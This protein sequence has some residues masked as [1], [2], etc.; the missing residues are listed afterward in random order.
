MEYRLLSFIEEQVE[1]AHVG[2]EAV[3]LLIYP[4]IPLGSELCV[5]E[6]LLR[7]NGITEIHEFIAFPISAIELA[8]PSAAERCFFTLLRE[9]LIRH[10]YVR[11]DV[12]KLYHL[13]HDLHVEVEEE[14]VLLLIERADVVLVILEEGALAVCRE[15]RIPMHVAP[16][17]MIRDTDILHRHRRI[18]IR[19]DGESQRTIGG[20]YDHAIAISL[21]DETLMALYQALIVAMEFLIPLHRTEIGGRK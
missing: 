17:G 14:L 20:G 7:A 19:R 13:L 4:V 12:E 3:L 8:F 11:S 15:E 2:Q 6:R 1:D 10:L 18:V 9:V 16:I 5:W 21:L